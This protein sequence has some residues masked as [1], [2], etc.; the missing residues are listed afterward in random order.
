MSIRDGA[1][2]HIVNVYS[3]DIYNA[4]IEDGVAHLGSPYCKCLFNRHLQC[5]Y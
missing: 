1:A 3:I 4:Y 2:P 5:L